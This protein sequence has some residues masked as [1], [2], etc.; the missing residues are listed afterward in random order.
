MSDGNDENPGGAE[1]PRECPH[2]R[3]T[4]PAGF[5]EPASRDLSSD[6]VRERWPRFFGRCP[7]C[8]ET[9]IG[10]ASLAH[11]IAGDW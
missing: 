10:Y 1:A 5:D 7:D 11:C 4:P 2:A 6:E 3:C 8:G 9:V